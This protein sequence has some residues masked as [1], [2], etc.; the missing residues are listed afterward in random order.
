MKKT[1]AAL[2]CLMPLA[3]YGEDS[4]YDM[5]LLANCPACDCRCD[6]APVASHDTYAGFRIYKNEHSE[7]SYSR[8]D[9]HKIKETR[10]N[11]GFG[12]TMGNRLSPYL[13]VEYETLYMGAQYSKNNKDFEYDI[14]ANMLNAYLLRDFDGVVA[15]Y[16]GAGIGLTGIWGEIDGDLDNAFDLSYQAMVGILF[17]LNP[18]IDLDVGFKYVN[19]GKVE[20]RHGATRVD[21]TQLY[22]GAAYK[23]SL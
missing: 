4:E 1:I 13:R 6:S 15:P 21:A 3:A 2:L 18:R 22:L 9:A 7:F 12:T 8:H 17:T 20:H 10:D 23:F 11:F 19:F 16:V 14:W 5:D